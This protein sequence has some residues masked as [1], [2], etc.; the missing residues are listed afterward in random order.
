M[1][2]TFS[3]S[4]V[5][6]EVMSIIRYS[7][8]KGTSTI[9]SGKS[10][11]GQHEAVQIVEKKLKAEGYRVYRGSAVRDQENL[12]YAPINQIMDQVERKTRVRELSDIIE[13]LDV[14]PMDGKSVLVVE[15][16]E[17]SND[18]T[19]FL[20]NY[21]SRISVGKNFHIIGTMSK[22]HK[23]MAQKLVKFLKVVSTESL[24]LNLEL[25]KPKPQDFLEIT[26][27]MGYHLP[28]GLLED[29]YR[30]ADGN[31]SVLD[32]FIRYY[33]A[34]GIIDSKGQL[35][36]QVYRFFLIPGSLSEF[37]NGIISSLKEEE[38]I[39]L[40]ILHI[41]QYSM[42]LEI[43][44]QLYHEPV[45]V[46]GRTMDNLIM[47]GLASNNGGKFSSAGG[48]TGMVILDR[49]GK[50]IKKDACEKAIT[51][52]KINTLPL[53]ARLNFF[54]VA[55]DY[56][57]VSEII[58]RE[59]NTFIRK[60]SSLED[61]KQFIDS[62]KEKIEPEETGRIL[63]LLKCNL[64]FNSGQLSEA[65]RIYESEKFQDI[66]P[67]SVT[68]TRASIYRELGN[69]G[70][71]ISILD[72][73]IG[74]GSFPP[75]AKA[76]ALL[77]IAE[78]YY[79]LENTEKALEFCKM[80]NELIGGKDYPELEARLNTILGNVNFYRNNIEEA[81]ENYLRSIEI[82]RKLG[83]WMEIT[84]SMN[85]LAALEEYIGD[86]QKSREILNKLMDYTYL[87]GDATL[88]SLG[89]YNT[90]V[91]ADIQGSL[92][93][94]LKNLDAAET[95][96]LL[97]GNMELVLRCR[98]AVILI[99]MKKMRFSDSIDEGKDFL[100]AQ[101]GSKSSLI[102][103]TIGIAGYLESGNPPEKEPVPLADPNHGDPRILVQYNMA[104]SFY[105]FLNSR[106]D[107][108]WETMEEA[109]ALS[110]QNGDAYFKDIRNLLDT[111]KEFF[112]FDR[113]KLRQIIY[114]SEEPKTSLSRA[115]MNGAGL[116][117]SLVNNEKNVEEIV[118]E[119]NKS[120]GNDATISDMVVRAMVAYYAIKL[121]IPYEQRSLDI[122][123][124][125]L[126]S[127]KP[128]KGYMGIIRIADGN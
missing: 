95:L 104:L 128:L 120:A 48:E 45:E 24:A 40:S 123:T 36:E 30:L 25:E 112:L 9:I 82:N 78:S 67:V 68:L 97:I 57:S 100:G 93:E 113:E 102:E 101:D 96:G 79:D 59:W 31:L 37:Y 86:Y 76:L 46:T 2:Q 98:E 117:L 6:R 10:G 64:L 81:R 23:G 70:K 84:R 118:H 58:R 32:Y 5:T 90:A 18:P 73:Q 49:I 69:P 47:Y 44:S 116:S 74:G 41:S 55:G 43:I 4:S 121:K 22:N 15:G 105:Y 103:N 39:L 11:Y 124:R 119:L 27:M 20:F 80:A 26:Q 87:T 88:R 72:S 94:A 63:Q 13:T 56:S 66:D 127:V 28:Y 62:V 14:I 33:R 12:K 16:L 107:K 29:S 65:L 52:G 8:G 50:K 114:G 109:L 17:L 89:R 122:I 85:N 71:S 35:D 106:K 99:L 83:I 92:D 51:S 115:V 61:L 21:L 126:S 38:L 110:A 34:K 108:A 125:I 3:I 1:K 111:L 42:D 19:K 77:T 60:F 7:E 54:M 53:Q 91:I 75:E